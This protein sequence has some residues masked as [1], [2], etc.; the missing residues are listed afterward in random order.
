MSLVRKPSLRVSELGSIRIGGY[1]FTIVV[2]VLFP[3][4]HCRNKLTAS[5]I[6]MYEQMF[7]HY[8]KD[9]SGSID[10]NELKALLAELGRQV[11]NDECKS[12]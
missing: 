12:P 3:H 5:E 6:S 10:A 11:R 9:K 1:V 7:S 2:V 4:L 8:D